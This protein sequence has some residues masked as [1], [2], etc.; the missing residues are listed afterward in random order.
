MSDI[1][2]TVAVPVELLKHS[3][4]VLR[5]NEFEQEALDLIALLPKPKPRLVAVDPNALPMSY[6]ANAAEWFDSQPDLLA[7]L[8]EVL[9][10]EVLSPELR[11]SIRQGFCDALGVD[12]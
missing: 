9:K 10:D 12:Q 6:F 7:L 5:A 4:R 11:A 3:A 1:E 8:D 2:E